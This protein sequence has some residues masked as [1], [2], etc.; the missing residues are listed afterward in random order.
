MSAAW[1]QPSAGAGVMDPPGAPAQLISDTA[2]LLVVER[3]GCGWCDKFREDLG[4]KYWNL[5][6][7]RRAPLSTSTRPMLVATS[8]IS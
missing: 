4:P 2:T 3:D 8:G 6:Q 1:D 7:Q 5:E